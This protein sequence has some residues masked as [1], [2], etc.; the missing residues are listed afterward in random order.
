MRQ[1]L[2]GTGMAIVLVSLGTPLLA[3]FVVPEIDGGSVTTGLGLL[4]GG[5]LMLRAR[6]ARK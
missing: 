5:I 3:G 6:M 4:A 1:A 2:Y